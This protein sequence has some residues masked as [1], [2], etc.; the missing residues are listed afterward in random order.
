MKKKKAQKAIRPTKITNEEKETLK[1]MLKLECDYALPDEIMDEFLSHGQVLH[2][3]KWHTVIAAGD[4]N[5]DVY[6]TMEGILRCWYWDENREKTAFF[7]TL[8]TMFIN[9]HTYF[10][11]QPSFY[12]FQSCTPAKLV[13]IKRRYFDELIERSPEFARWNLR[14]AQT[15]LYFFE[16]KHKL[17]TG[18]AKERY[19]TLLKEIPTIVQE[20]PLHVVA[21]YLGITPQHLSRLRRTL[22]D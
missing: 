18:L 19:L 1:E 6:I 16:V 20:V 13:R 5:P 21:S 14:L 4:E 11:G 2:T 17:S 3:R 15:Q 10:G 7:S 9:Y 22:L 12:H 8:P